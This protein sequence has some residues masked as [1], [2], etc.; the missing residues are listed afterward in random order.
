MVL[1]NSRI[2]WLEET[3]NI[4]IPQRIFRQKPVSYA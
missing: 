3:S 1:L 2:T 4:S